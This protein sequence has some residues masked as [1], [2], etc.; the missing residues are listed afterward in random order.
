MNLKRI[1]PSS[2]DVAE[3]LSDVNENVVIAAA[4]L[5]RQQENRDVSGAMQQLELLHA[6]VTLAHSLATQQFDGLINK[7]Q[8]MIALEVIILYKLKQ[9]RDEKEIHHGLSTDQS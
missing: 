4:S 1:L 6:P 7:F 5:I 9:M 3:I 2:I 8:H